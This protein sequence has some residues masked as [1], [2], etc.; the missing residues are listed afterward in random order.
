MGEMVKIVSDSEV[1]AASL[2]CILG[3]TQ[4]RIRQLQEDRIIMRGDSGFFNVRD[5]VQG[6]IDYLVQQAKPKKELSEEE[7]KLEKIK[8]ISDAQLRKTRAD[9]AAIELNEMQGKIH[10]AED[11]ENLTGELL[12]TLRSY[13]NA[14]PGRLAV[15]VAA[16]STAPECAA[17]IRKEVQLILKELSTHKYERKRY[18]EL[19]R[20]RRKWEPKDSEDE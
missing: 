17:V 12:S 9:M 10:R 7:K 18:A 11:I 16:V 2:S 4:R 5:A 1:N 19:V 14:L 3:I 13:L 8:N 15:E 20:E 6:Y